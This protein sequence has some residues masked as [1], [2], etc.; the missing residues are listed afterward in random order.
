MFAL[1]HFFTFCKN[2]RV[3]LII[4]KNSVKQATIEATIIKADGTRVPL[5]VVAKIKKPNIFQRL[6]KKIGGK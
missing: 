4:T 2:G 6:I 3:S 5:G 1:L